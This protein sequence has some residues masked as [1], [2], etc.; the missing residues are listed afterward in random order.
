MRIGDKI[1][2]RIFKQQAIKKTQRDDT[3][4]ETHQGDTEVPGDANDWQ[5]EPDAPGEQVRMDTG[6]TESDN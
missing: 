3:K 2:E 1:A 5:R 4:E 6:D